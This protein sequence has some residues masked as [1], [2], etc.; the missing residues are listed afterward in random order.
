MPRGGRILALLVLLTLLSWSGRAA[1]QQEKRYALLIGNQAYDASVGVLK[2]PHNDIE[3]VA[4]SLKGQGFEVLPL[5]KD[6]RR[7]TILGAVRDLAS[8]LRVAE[9]A[10]LFRMA[11]A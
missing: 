6:A 5:V 7:S 1:A 9:A 4:K 8:R 10:A 11:A 2:N 3:L